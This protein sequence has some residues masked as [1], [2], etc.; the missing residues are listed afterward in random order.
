MRIHFPTLE[1]AGVGVEPTSNGAGSPHACVGWATEAPVRMEAVRGHSPGGG[2]VVGLWCIE[3]CG[4]KGGKAHLL[5]PD[6][7]Q[8]MA[9]AAM[10]PARPE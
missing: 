2:P 3:G 8:Q 5:G 4:H 1:I 7:P 10:K 9:E 6:G